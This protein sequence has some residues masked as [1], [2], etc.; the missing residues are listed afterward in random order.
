MDETITKCKNHIPNKQLNMY[1]EGLSQHTNKKYTDNEIKEMIA[2]IILTNPICCGCLKKDEET[3]SRLRIC[4][5]CCLDY[6][7]SEQCMKNHW[8][9]H[10]KYCNNID[11]DWPENSPFRPAFIRTNK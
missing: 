10:S 9:I 4:S 2:Q 11:G 3:L 6:W 7:C 5:E 8:P 1:K